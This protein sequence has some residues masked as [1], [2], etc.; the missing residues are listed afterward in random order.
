ME[1]GLKILKTVIDIGIEHPFKLLHITDTHVTRGDPTGLQ[2]WWFNR[3]Y[4]GCAEDYF[5]R[6]MDYAKKNDLIVL[7]TGDLIDFQSEE[8]FA[9]V[10]EHLRY[11]DYI[12]AAGNHDFYNHVE[13]P[14]EDDENKRRKT[15]FIA[16]HIKSN[17]YFDSRIIGGVNIVTL[18]NTYYTV[19]EDQ[20]EA[21]K[22]EVAKGYPIILAMHIP[23]FTERLAVRGLSGDPPLLYMLGSPM[24]FLGQLSLERQRQQKA[25]E[26]TLRFI[27]YVKNESAIKAL[28][29][30]HLHLNDED[31]LGG[32]LPQYV[33]NGS[34][35][36]YVR[37]ITVK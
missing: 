20:L 18:D 24:E 1:N 9:F 25:D 8:N 37:E 31:V 19:K 11:V 16:P 32:R 36:G 27:D 3:D 34:F 13:R 15:P 21:L 29:T 30:G 12:Y 26:T 22:R 5:L 6:A 7:H 35:D 33:T 23:F 14:V 4:E 10:D 2:A 28:I 17:L